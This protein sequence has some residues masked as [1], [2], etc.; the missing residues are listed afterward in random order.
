MKK[1]LLILIFVIFCGQ[2]L[3]DKNL[4]DQDEYTTRDYEAYCLRY[5]DLKNPYAHRFVKLQGSQII[6]E[7]IVKDN[8]KIWKPVGKLS[9]L[10]EGDQNEISE[11]ISE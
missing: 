4:L 10:N 11:T 2:D 3:K 1:Y 8:V 5:Y 7:P 9:K 6:C